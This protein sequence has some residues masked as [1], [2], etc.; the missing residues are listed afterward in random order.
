M[1]RPL[2]LRARSS[3]PFVVACGFLGLLA[4]TCASSIIAPIAPYQLSAWGYDDRD[5][6]TLTGWLVAIT[7]AASLV[8]SLVFAMLLDRLKRRRGPFVAAALLDVASNLLNMFAPNVAVL[9]VGRALHGVASAAA[10]SLCFTLVAEVVDARYVGTA[11]SILLVR[12][13]S[14]A[15][16]TR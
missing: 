7:S 8:A 10:W 1:K 15:A 13:G 4:E 16:L 2:L 12:G 11:L 6:A 9:L 14:P 5:V 3:V